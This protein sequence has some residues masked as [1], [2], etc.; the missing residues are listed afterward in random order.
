MSDENFEEVPDR[1]DVF[2]FRKYLLKELIRFKNNHEST[3]KNDV[4]KDF[5]TFHHLGDVSGIEKISNEEFKS[6]LNALK[7]YNFR[8]ENSAKMVK[9]FDTFELTISHSESLTI[10]LKSNT[11]ENVVYSINVKKHRKGKGRY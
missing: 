9:E 4:F 1:K 6:V 10:S 8:E 2:E 11:A 3:D 7:E 5:E